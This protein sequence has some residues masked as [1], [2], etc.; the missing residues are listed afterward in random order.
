V[1]SDSA[2]AND[3][4]RAL[5]I[6]PIFDSA[7][8]LDSIIPR[9]SFIH[10][11][12]DDVL[13]NDRIVSVGGGPVIPPP[14]PPPPQPV[15]QLPSQ[16]G[17]GATGVGPGSGTSSLSTA[18]IH[19]VDYDVC[20]ENF[21]R[22]LATHDSSSPP[23]IQL[24]TT[25]SGV[26]DATLSVSQPFANQNQIT[27]VDRY[28]FEAPLA[29]GETV[30]TIFAVDR[31]SNVQRTLVQVEGCT[32]SLVFAD[33]Q[34]VLPH[35]FDV[36]Y[37][38]NSTY[39]RPV[40]YSYITQGQDMTVSAIA[41]SPLVP[42]AKAELFFTILGTG[43]QKVLPMTLTPL[44]LPDL[45]NV[46]VISSM[47]PA[48][49]LKGPAVE[50]WIRVV[51]EEG[52]VQESAHSIIGVKPVGYSSTSSVEMDITRIKAQGTTLKP[53]TYLTNNADIPVYG[54]VS[55]VADGKKVYSKPV[56]LTPGQNI[57]NLEW[58]IPKTD[59]VTSYEMQTQLDAYGTSYT[60]GMAT[61]DTFTR[62]KIVPVS[63]QHSI[64]PATD[65]LGNVIARPAMMYSSNE[66]S[67]SFR[68]VSPD[69]T[70][71]IGDGCL[72]EGSTLK[73]RGAI[74]S[75]LVDGHIY[76]VRYSGDD[77]PLERFSITSLD[78][79]LGEWKVDIVE[80]SPFI[81]SAADD[82]PIKIQ[83]RAE[84]SPLVTVR[85]E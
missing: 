35:I 50:F 79:V 47:I 80:D 44:R 29:Q 78:S 9:V 20:T 70:C 1:L 74:D 83:Y 27:L 71:V 43:Q 41:Q 11:V 72:V 59:A 32:G 5:S 42:L 55:L 56:L 57:I 10:L 46:S 77:S 58:K 69:G 12:F 33:D 85:S 76:R 51:T 38:T 60:T 2:S 34:I 73:H 3:I 63:D 36:K 18:K 13:S 49:M 23:K 82:V 62:T 53:T 37:Q 7:T 64:V 65:E 4:L 84:D 28:L 54:E 48:N 26:V 81:A 40:E 68:V 15:P 52:V 66:G 17:S 8:V 21:V 67:G 30:F 14:V 61:L 6:K 75:V 31:L 24:L 22:I 25:K 45:E 16:S 39:I 19:K